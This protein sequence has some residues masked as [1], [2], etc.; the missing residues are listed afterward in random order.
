MLAASQ[1]GSPLNVGNCEARWISWAMIA[2]D[3]AMPQPRRDEELIRSKPQSLV[4][5]SSF[6]AVRET[7]SPVRSRTEAEVD[8]R[9]DYSDSRRERRHTSPEDSRVNLDADAVFRQG[10]EFIHGI[11]RPFRYYITQSYHNIAPKSTEN[12]PATSPI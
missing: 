8:L 2:Y 4:G 11:S 10:N 1:V 9:D 5:R 3:S 12:P 7:I 6:G